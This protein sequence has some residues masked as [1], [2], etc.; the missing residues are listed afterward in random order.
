MPTTRPY[1][2]TRPSL[3]ITLWITQP[4]RLLM[5]KMMISSPI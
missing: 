5:M 2:I 4:R 1:N 3:W